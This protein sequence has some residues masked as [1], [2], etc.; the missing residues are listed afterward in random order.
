MGSIN[1]LQAIRPDTAYL[2]KIIENSLLADWAIRI[3]YHG[4]ETANDC[5]QTWGKPFFALTSA[6]AVLAAL[7]GCYSKYPD[8]T[9]RINAEKFRPQSHILYTVYDP[10]WLP[11]D[12]GPKPQTTSR[13]IP[14][15]TQ[16]P[17]TRFGISA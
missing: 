14:R 17:S 4:G 10:Q 8:R 6:E 3:E 11:A 7:V 5:W 13:Q 16:Q 2:R 12:T 15:A 9:I 1:Y